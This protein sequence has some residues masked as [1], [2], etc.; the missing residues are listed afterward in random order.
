M[1]FEWAYLNH[2]TKGEIADEAFAEQ[3]QEYMYRS[4]NE[5]YQYY[6]LYDLPVRSLDMLLDEVNADYNFAVNTVINTSDG[7]V[8]VLLTE[9]GKYLN[10]V[11]FARVGEDDY[12]T[13]CENIDEC[14][15]DDIQEKYKR[16]IKF[17]KGKIK[18][19]CC[20]WFVAYLLGEDGE[21]IEEL[22][23]EIY[24]KYN[25]GYDDLLD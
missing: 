16:E 12:E 19:G 6:R 5:E 1:S 13:A 21:E 22:I 8:L 17:T 11:E 2:F 20:D 15:D 14:L 4:R 7:G 18:E 25:A 23:L 10:H 9:K 24:D 3:I